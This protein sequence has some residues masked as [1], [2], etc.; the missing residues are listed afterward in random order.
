MNNIKELK[1][2]GDLRCDKCDFYEPNESNEKGECRYMPP[3]FPVVDND[4][5]CGCH[6]ELFQELTFIQPKEGQAEPTPEVQEAST[7][8]GS[9]PEPSNAESIDE[10]PF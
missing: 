4:H 7:P 10:I 2:R 5:W 3:K 1:Q 6:S 8:E 9:K